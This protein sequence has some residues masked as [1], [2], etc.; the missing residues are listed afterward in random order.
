ML[1]VSPIVWFMGLSLGL[2][3]LLDNLNIVLILAYTFGAI[4]T[5]LGIDKVAR[6]LEKRHNRKMLKQAMVRY[7]AKIR[8][9]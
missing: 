7:K 3:M 8:G 9:K 6:C 4:L 2:W 5:I 1:A